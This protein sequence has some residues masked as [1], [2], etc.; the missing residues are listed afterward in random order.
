MF[1]E[2]YFYLLYIFAFAALVPLL[3]IPLFVVV[4]T[5]DLPYGVAASTQLDSPALKVLPVLLVLP[6]AQENVVN[7]PPVLD[8][9]FG[10]AAVAAVQGHVVVG[11]VEGTS[12]V[13]VGGYAVVGGP[14]FLGLLVGYYI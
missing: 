1:I 11:L 7:P 6:E 10:Q 12:H 8:T 14:K 5:V 9:G 4:D 13:G 3:L 2:P